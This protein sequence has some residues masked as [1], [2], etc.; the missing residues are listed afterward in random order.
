MICRITNS[1]KFFKYIG[2]PLPIKWLLPMRVIQPFSIAGIRT[3]GH[4]FYDQDPVLEQLE[5][6]NQFYAKE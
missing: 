6:L 1:L 3:F 4:L 5:K 2:A